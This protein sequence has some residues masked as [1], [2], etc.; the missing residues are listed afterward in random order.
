ML[1]TAYFDKSDTHGPSPT[2]IMACFLGHARQ[3][4]LFGRR[5]RLLQKRDGLTVFHA[6]EFR[7]KTGAFA[8]WSDTKGMQLVNDLTFRLELC[9]PMKPAL[10]VAKRRLRQVAVSW[11]AVRQASAC[12]IPTYLWHRDQS[13]RVGREFS[14]RWR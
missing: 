6:T 12:Q 11:T 2:V 9:Q 7:N 5:L 8:G 4:E 10:P 13:T 1:Y 3:W 14:L